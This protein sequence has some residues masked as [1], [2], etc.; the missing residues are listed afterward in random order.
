MES[1]HEMQ[2]KICEAESNGYRVE[3][4]AIGKWPDYLKCNSNH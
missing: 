1:D 4:H 3:I 2:R